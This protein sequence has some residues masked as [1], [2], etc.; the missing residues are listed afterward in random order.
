MYGFYQQPQIIGSLAR[1]AS[2]AEVQAAPVNANGAPTLFLLENEPAMY[3]VSLQGGQ[4]SIQGF[5]MVPLPTAQEAT[6]NRLNNLEAAL[7]DIKNLL[8]GKV[9]TNESNTAVTQPSDTAA[10]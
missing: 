5:R 2:F 9:A 8:E 10:V 3:L 7:T 1:A 6:E 4:K